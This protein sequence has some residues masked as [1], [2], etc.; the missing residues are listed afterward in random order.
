MTVK[1]VF[2]VQCDGPCRGWL[3]LPDTRVYRGVNDFRHAELTVEPTAVNAGLWPGEYAARTAARNNGWDVSGSGATSPATLLCPTCKSNPLG[4]RI[5]KA[6]PCHGTH[7]TWA[8][9]KECA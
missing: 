7:A 5:P 6:A 9:C 2:R 4:I 3:S 8:V 1:A